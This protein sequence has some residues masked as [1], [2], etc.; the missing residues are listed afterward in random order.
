[1]ANEARQETA[2]TALEVSGEIAEHNDCCC[3]VDCPECASREYPSCDPDDSGEFIPGYFLL[4]FSGMSDYSSVCCSELN[5][6]YIVTAT[7]ACHGWS[8]SATGTC[9][10]FGIIFSQRTDI[11]VTIQMRKH[12][13]SCFRYGW[14]KPVCFCTGS[15]NNGDDYAPGDPGSGGSCSF[16]PC[17]AFGNPCD[18][19]VMTEVP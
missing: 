14:G 1:M 13:N 4:T 18:D 17:D 2:G 8:G 16:Q 11:G 19:C 7:T 9:G 3:V 5:N 15:R 12:P 10:T 6:S